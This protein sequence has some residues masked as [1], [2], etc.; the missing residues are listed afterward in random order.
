MI[1]LLSSGADFDKDL[2]KRSNAFI[3]YNFDFGS[4][5]GLTLGNVFGVNYDKNDITAKNSVYYEGQ[6]R[7][8]QEMYY[9]TVRHELSHVWQYNIG[10]IYAAVKLLQEQICNATRIYDPYTTK[11]NL[12]YLAKRRETQNSKPWFMKGD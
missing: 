3:F 7:T 12:E 10:G 11:W 8:Q 4:H 6:L 5:G 9:M 2:S 1:Y